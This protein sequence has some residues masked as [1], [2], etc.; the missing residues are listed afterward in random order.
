MLISVNHTNVSGDYSS[1]TPKIPTFFINSC[2][3]LSFYDT[4]NL[5]TLER[6]HPRQWVEYC[7]SI[8][9]IL[10]AFMYST[11]LI[12]THAKDESGNTIYKVVSGNS[13]KKFKEV[14]DHDMFI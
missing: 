3:V 7:V 13:L 6:N 4:G 9:R 11:K 10:S 5:R 14:T 8:R 2:T 12:E 1:R